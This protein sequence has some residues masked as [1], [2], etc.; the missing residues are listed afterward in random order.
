MARKDVRV[1][2]LNPYSRYFGLP[3]HVFDIFDIDIELKTSTNNNI[4]IAI[5]M[6]GIDISIQS[7]R[8]FCR[9]NLD[10]TFLLQNEPKWFQNG[11]QIAS[12][13]IKID[14]GAS[15]IDC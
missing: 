3:K 4:D 5:D 15:K 6:K 14:L 2:N 12:K 9:A 10:G 8:A 11:S 1:Q 13:S 7:L